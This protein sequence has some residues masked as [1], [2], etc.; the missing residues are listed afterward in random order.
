MV[1]N[2][3]IQRVSDWFRKTYNSSQ[4]YR[5]LD[6]VNKVGKSVYGIQSSSCLSGISFC[7]L[8]K[9]IKMGLLQ[10]EIDWRTTK[11]IRLLHLAWIVWSLASHQNFDGPVS[12][13]KSP[14]LDQSNVDLIFKLRGWR[15]HSIVR[16]QQ[17]R[18][19]ILIYV[20]PIGCIF[21]HITIFDRSVF[22]PY[23]PIYPN[24]ISS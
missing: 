12:S 20:Q 2:T 9:S 13:L 1:K 17:M 18:E 24:E 14:K 6:G 5:Y 11:S 4:T 21:M 16:L 8:L 10:V 7:I 22:N 15:D 3:S 19:S 23:W